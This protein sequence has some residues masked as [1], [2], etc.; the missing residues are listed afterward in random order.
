MV[1]LVV[2]ML[3][4]PFAAMIYSV[5][6]SERTAPACKLQHSTTLKGSA[7]WWPHSCSHGNEAQTSLVICGTS[8]RTMLCV[9]CRCP[10]FSVCCLSS[11][12]SSSSSSNPRLHQ[13]QCQTCDTQQGS[14][15]PG[16]CCLG[17]AVVQGAGQTTTAVGP[18]TSNKGQQ[19]VPCEYH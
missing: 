4:P 8:D 2:N 17:V 13:L 5:V 14:W 11:G 18:A 7:A 1:Q 3:A 15:R 9:V 19:V 12:G 10:C 6:L 16:T